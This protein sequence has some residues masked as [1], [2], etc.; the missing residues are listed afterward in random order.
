MGIQISEIIPREEI[1]I[2]ELNGKTIAIDAM[3]TLYQFLTSIRQQDGTPLMDSK[4]NISSHLSGI[5]YRNIALLEEGIN[6]IYVFDGVPSELKYEE[7]QK[8]RERKEI[9]KEKY[10]EAKEEGDVSEMRKYSQQIVKIDSKII[11]ESKELLVSMGIPVLDSLNE[12]EAEAAILARKKLVWASASQ[13]YDSLLYGTPRLIRNLTLSRKKRIPSGILVDTKIEM[14]ELQNVLNKL[15]I[16]RDQ[17]ICLGILV[18]TDFNP[19]GVKGIGQ[20]RALEIVQKNIYP[21]KIFEFIEKSDKYNLE[22]DWQRIFQEFKT[23]EGTKED[24]NLRGEINFE[25]IKEIL[26]ARDFSEERINNGLERLRN[27]LEKK[28]QTG[29]GEFF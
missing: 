4:G 15:Q 5:F 9:A 11:R 3:N 21:V 20:K 10:E 17:L 6:P 12:G 23:Y 19:G 28:K 29:L 1:E 22:F 26:L 16:D 25:K 24:L 13:D 2:K 14:V 27:I 8:R 7:I 18:G